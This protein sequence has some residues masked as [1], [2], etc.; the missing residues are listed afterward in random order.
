MAAVPTVEDSKCQFDHKQ[1]CTVHN[2]ARFYR[3]SIFDPDWHDE[4]LHIKWQSQTPK[5]ILVPD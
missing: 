4:C 1:F 5:P 3:G 2:S